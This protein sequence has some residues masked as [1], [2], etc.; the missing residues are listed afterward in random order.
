M[1]RVVFLAGVVL[2]L[3]M[4]GLIWGQRGRG[5]RREVRGGGVMVLD[6]VCLTY[7]PQSR[8]HRRRVGG[9]DYAFCSQECADA[10]PR[11]APSD[12]ATQPVVPKGRA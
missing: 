6:P 3:V 1:I 5:G 7:I 12:Q 4:G 2:V 10:F 8:S 11:F 9:V